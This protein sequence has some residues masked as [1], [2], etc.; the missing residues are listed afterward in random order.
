MIC[1]PP[2]S[3]RD[4]HVELAA[5]P[6]CGPGSQVMT[7]QGEVP[8]EWLATGDKL[9]TRDHGFQPLL[10]LGR[11]RFSAEDMARRP[12]LAPLEIVAKALGGGRPSHLTA[13]APRTRV[14]LSGLEVALNTGV[15]EAL[16]EVGDLVDGAAVVAS[17]GTAGGQYTYL[18]LPV[19]EVVQINGLWVETLLLDRFARHA[20][21][22]RVSEDLVRRV[23]ATAGHARAAK[24]C[25]A[26]WEVAAIRGGDERSAPRLIERVA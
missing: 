14:L 22:G 23:G 26:A 15:D 1:S 8:V 13:L 12:T 6:A 4:A 3:P 21:E 5:L 17:R 16:A 7:D 18:L 20:L 10:W 11:A 19:H 25:L 2:I 24:L 9:L